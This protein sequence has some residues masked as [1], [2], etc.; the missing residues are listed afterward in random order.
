MTKSAEHKL[1]E[2]YLNGTGTNLSSSDVSRL[3]G[4]DDAIRARITNVAASEAGLAEPG[5]DSIHVGINRGLSWAEFGAVL[6]ENA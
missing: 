4:P 5:G 3:V 6:G 1:Y 2:A